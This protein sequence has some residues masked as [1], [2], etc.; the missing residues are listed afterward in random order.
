MT[1]SKTFLQQHSFLR[2]EARTYYVVQT[3][4]TRTTNQSWIQNKS[5]GASRIFDIFQFTHPCNVS[6]RCGSGV[7]WTSL[8]KKQICEHSRFKHFQT[9]TRNLSFTVE[10][11]KSRLLGLLFSFSC[12][13][14]KLLTIPRK[15]K[16]WVFHTNASFKYNLYLRKNP[17]WSHAEENPIDS[18]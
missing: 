13:Q 7:I 2:N 16:C 4:F 5:Y 11:F 12:C 14:A 15:I 18:R 1:K 3:T 9:I 17:A 10:K 8:Q 6:C